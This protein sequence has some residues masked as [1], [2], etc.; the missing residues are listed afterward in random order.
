MISKSID[1][2]PVAVSVKKDGKCYI[3]S[4]DF[5]ITVIGD[6]YIDCQ[7]K[8]SYYFNAIL[9]YNRE[10]NI[11]MEFKTS[12]QDVSSMCKGNDDFPTTIKLAEGRT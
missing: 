8:A 11:S 1:E 12:Y 6:N 5:G 4:P 10:H 3:T 9:Y 2:L 7:S